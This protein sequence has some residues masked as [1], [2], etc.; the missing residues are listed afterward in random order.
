MSWTMTISRGLRRQGVCG[1]LYDMVSAH[2]PAEL[3][4]RFAVDAVVDLLT[5]CED[6]SFSAGDGPDEGDFV[7]FATAICSG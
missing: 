7:F 4:V 6:E 5:V 3:E 2:S 1:E